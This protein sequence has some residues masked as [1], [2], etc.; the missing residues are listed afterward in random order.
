MKRGIGIVI[1]LG[2]IAAA[3]ACVP[4]MP[5]S[6]SV[7][8]STPEPT[9]TK[10]LPTPTEKGTTLYGAFA[11]EGK[12]F[13]HGRVGDP[14][15]GYE[16]S[17]DFGPWMPV[18]V[19]DSTFTVIGEVE[20]Q[21]GVT[22]GS[23]C[24]LNWEIKLPPSYRYRVCAWDCSRLSNP[25]WFDSGWIDVRAL[26]EFEYSVQWNIKS[27]YERSGGETLPNIMR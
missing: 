11:L 5:A 13:R 20:V 22:N 25:D 9:A 12:R 6:T 8:T 1:S 16:K 2:I 21:P 23:Q 27:D 18:R 19:Y 7:P 3:L 14:C 10:I 15:Q 4:E 26:E 24:L 17:S